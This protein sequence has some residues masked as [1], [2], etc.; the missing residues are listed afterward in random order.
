M[1]GAIERSRIFKNVLLYGSIWFY[2]V[3]YAVRRNC[4]TSYSFLA[5]EQSHPSQSTHNIHTKPRASHEWSSTSYNN[6]QPHSRPFTTI[7]AHLQSLPSLRV[8]QPS[9]PPKHHHLTPC[10]LVHTHRVRAGK[11][12]YGISPYRVTV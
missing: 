10:A 7:A 5:A 12:I 8:Y 3:K 9:G 2:D 6:P 1:D 4:C 11:E